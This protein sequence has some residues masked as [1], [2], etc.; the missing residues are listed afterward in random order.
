MQSAEATQSDMIAC[1]DEIFDVVMDCTGVVRCQ[2]KI[3]TEPNILNRRPLHI[4]HA[5]LQH[6]SEYLNNFANTLARLHYLWCMSV[7]YVAVGKRQKD[8]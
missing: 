7:Q 8:A 4:S 1:R 3:P 2:K 6:F 5:L